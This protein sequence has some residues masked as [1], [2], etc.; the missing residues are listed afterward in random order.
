MLVSFVFETSR[1]AFS[2][3][4]DSYIILKLFRGGMDKF[5]VE[6]GRLHAIRAS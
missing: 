3:I 4:V 5:A 6:L 2:S 1:S